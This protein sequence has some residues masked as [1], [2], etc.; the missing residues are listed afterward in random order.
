MLKEDLI[1]AYREILSTNNLKFRELCELAG[2]S[3]SQLASVLKHGAEKVSIE[4][5]ESGLNKLGFGVSVNFF[6]LGDDE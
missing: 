6:N 4:K 1:L 2:L 3:E 5:M